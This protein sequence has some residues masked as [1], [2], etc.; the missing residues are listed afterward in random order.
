MEYVDFVKTRL[1]SITLTEQRTSL[2]KLVFTINTNLTQFSLIKI[3][4]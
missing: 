4:N 3:A 2:I 1:V